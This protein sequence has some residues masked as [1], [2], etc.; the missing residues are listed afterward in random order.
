MSIST[1]VPVRYSCSPFQLFSHFKLTLVSGKVGASLWFATAGREVK[2]WGRGGAVEN[3]PKQST[4]I[5]FC[6]ETR[7]FSRSLQ[8]IAIFLLLCFFAFV[9]TDLSFYLRSIFHLSSVYVPVLFCQYSIYVPSMFRP[10]SIYVPSMFRQ[11][12]V[13]VPIVL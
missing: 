5:K 3:I 11:R 4:V 8:I 12:S 2:G 7:S 13:H 6:K 10:C 9:P 1:S